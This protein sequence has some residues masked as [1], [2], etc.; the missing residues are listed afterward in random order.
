[1]YFQRVSA[2]NQNVYDN[3]DTPQNMSPQSRKAGAI[4]PWTRTVQAPTPLA[5][6]QAEGPV[7]TSFLETITQ[8]LTTGSSTDQLI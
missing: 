4:M 6:E 5:V 2:M 3:K 8:N 7:T 1:M